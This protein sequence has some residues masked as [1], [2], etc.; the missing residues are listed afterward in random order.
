[1]STQSPAFGMLQGLMLADHRP[2]PAALVLETKY[3]ENCTRSFVRPPKPMARVDVKGG[4]FE[5][6]VRGQHIFSNQEPGVVLKDVGQRYCMECQRRGAAPIDLSEYK[7]QLPTEAQQKH[8]YH[9]PHYDDSIAPA[10]VQKHVTNVMP[11]PPKRGRCR[12]PTIKDRIINAFREHA[13]L[14]FEQLVDVVPELLTPMRA[15]QHVHGT[16]IR[17][18]RVGSAERRVNRGIAPGIYALAA[19]N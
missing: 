3:C 8:S 10:M 17:L 13:K 16:G 15:A 1:M 11:V 14:S 6:T 12:T 2:M 18:K 19:I 7:A 9:L 5:A 4:Y